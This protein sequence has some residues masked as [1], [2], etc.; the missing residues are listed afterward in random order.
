M[1]ALISNAAYPSDPVFINE[2]ELAYSLISSLIHVYLNHVVK[3]KNKVPC[4]IEIENTI[5]KSAYSILVKSLLQRRDLAIHLEISKLN[6][7]VW[8]QQVREWDLK[9][10]PKEDGLARYCEH[11]RQFENFHVIPRDPD[12]VFYSSESLN[13]WV[14][15]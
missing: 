14:P 3:H 9:D 7:S 10:Q 6:I 5:D 4:R 8:I 15:L 11:I 1:V 12:E 13:S 2:S